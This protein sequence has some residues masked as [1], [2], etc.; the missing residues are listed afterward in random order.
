MQGRILLLM[1]VLGLSGCTP[2]PIPEPANAKAANR[3]VSTVLL[4]P[5][6]TC[7]ELR[8]GFDLEHLPLAS[9]PA[10]IG[11]NYDEFFL[12]RPDEVNLRVW[13]I[14]AALNRGTIVFSMGS[15]GEI[16]CYLFTARLLANNGWN[17]VMY[18]YQGFGM[19]DGEADLTTMPDDLDVVLDWVLANGSHDQVTLFALSIGTL[20]TIDAATRRP[21]DI[22]AVIL[23]SPVALG[24]LLKAYGDLLQD[25]LDTFLAYLDPRLVS[26]ELIGDLEMPVLFLVGE[27]DF[28]TG[29][30][31]VATLFDRAADPKVLIEFPDIGHARSRFLETGKYTREVE[32]FLAEVW[33]QRLPIE[34]TGD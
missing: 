17:V 1:T 2:T 32:A 34:A 27:N 8:T 10:D 12:T 18:E 33:G 24:E 29:P 15:V 14:H 13:Q 3:V 26:E 22:N 23:D 28:L 31:S 21:Q 7:D 9:T 25:Q 19:S 5:T 11:L 16:A 6:V 20:P 4:N 30:T